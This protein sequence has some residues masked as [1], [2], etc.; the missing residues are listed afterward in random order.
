MCLHNNT[1]R[2]ERRTT[3]MKLGVALVLLCEL[4]TCC[5]IF[6]TELKDPCRDKKCPYGARC[7]ASI[8]GLTATCE[9]PT[10]CP[11]YGDHTGSRPVCGSD[12]TDYKDQCELRRAACAANREV[13]V[14][15]HG[16]CGE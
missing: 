4:S 2:Y 5:Y 6:P 8:D 1:V 11:A 15:F 12:G 16:K 9:C 3:E 13:A 14:R 7:V 10:R